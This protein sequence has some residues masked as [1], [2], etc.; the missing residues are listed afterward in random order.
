VENTGQMLIVRRLAEGLE[1]RGYATA[2]WFM[3]DGGPLFSEAAG[4]GLSP[5]VIGWSGSRRDPVGAWRFFRTLRSSDFAI[6]HQHYGGRLIRHVITKATSARLVVHLHGR[7]SED[8]FDHP[9]A[10]RISGADAIVATS[11]AVART[12]VSDVP[13]RVVHPG[14]E[15]TALQRRQTNP[16]RPVVGTAARLVPVKGV[17]DLVQAFA[18]VH[19]E[20]GDARLEIAGAGFDRPRLEREVEQMDLTSAVTFLG[21]RPD[22]GD[23]LRG[24]DVFAQASLEEA[25]GIA[26]LEAMAAGL[27]VVATRVGGVPELVEHGETGWLVPRGDVAAL[28]ARMHALLLDA[29]RR[30]AMGA[31]ARARGAAVFSVEQMVS[32]IS[33]VYDDVLA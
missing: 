28:A 20:L 7:V 16:A 8:A 4:C 12:V 30:L 14:V 26:A 32:K 11:A 19:A 9:L 31:A 17:L 23:L 21:W 25:F 5:R 33:A 10:Q 1:G 3:T 29:D 27:P 22:L 13:A 15:I 24:W 2:V 18:I 6:V